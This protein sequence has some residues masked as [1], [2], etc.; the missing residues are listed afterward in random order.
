MSEPIKPALT[1]EEWEEGEYAGQ[2]PF[3]YNL[4]P[5]GDLCLWLEDGSYIKLR[6]A[7]LAALALHGQPFGFTWELYDAMRRAI[8]AEEKDNAL[9]YDDDKHEV[10]RLAGQGLERIAALLPPRP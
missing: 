10:R 8:E 4:G 3:R 1:P 5:A 7:P 2:P 6:P 9:C